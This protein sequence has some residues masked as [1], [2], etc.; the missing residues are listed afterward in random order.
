MEEGENCLAVGDRDE[1][2]SVQESIENRAGQ[3]DF[4]QMARAEAT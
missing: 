2:H 1:E 3:N 4:D